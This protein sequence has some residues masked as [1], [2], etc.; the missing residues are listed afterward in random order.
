LKHLSRIS[1]SSNVYIQK[2]TGGITKLLGDTARSFFLGGP[3]TDGRPR[4]GGSHDKLVIARSH[5]HQAADQ[6][7][8]DAIFM[9]AN[10]NF[11][12]NYSHPRNLSHAFQR[13]QQLADLNG[14]SSAQHMIGFYYASGIGGVVKEDQA[15]AMLYYTFAAEQGNERAQ[16]ALAYRYHFGIGTSKNCQSAVRYWQKV[17]KRAIQHIRTGPPG[18]HM[19]IR[20][21]YRIADDTGGIYGEGASVTSAGANAKVGPANSDAHASHSDILE[22]LD[23]IS[24]KGDLKAT[25]SLGRMY[26][27]GARDM[28]PDMGAAKKYFLEVARKYWTKAGKVRS[29]PTAQ[30][31]QLAAKAAGYLGWMFLR[32]EGTEQN[33]DLAKKWLK[34]GVT[35][36]NSLSQYALGLMYLDGLSVPK[37][38]KQA[39]N[40]FSAAADQDHGPSQARL[41]ILYLDAGDIK[42]ALMYFELAARKGSSIEA[43]Y[44]LA[45]SERGGIGQEASCQSAAYHFKHLVE[46]AEPI[47]TSF[48]EANAAYEAGD[49]DAALINYMLIAE[50]GYEVAQTNVAYLLDRAA[51]R[52]SFIHLPLPK[53]VTKVFRSAISI[54]L[55]PSLALLYWTRSARQFNIDALVKM[56]DYYLGGIGAPASETKAAACYQAAA[57]TMQSA[58]ALWNIG[59]MYENGLGGYEQDFHLAK[60][61]YDQALEI[62]REA[63]LPVKLALLKLRLRSRWNEWTRGSAISIQDEPRKRRRPGS[64]GEWIA[65]FLAAE[66]DAIAGRFYDDGDEGD[67][68]YEAASRLGDLTDEELML[69]LFDGVVE[70]GIILLLAAVLA[71]LVIY[72]RQ[73]ADRRAR[74]GDELAAGLAEQAPLMAEEEEEEQGRDNGD[75]EPGRDRNLFPRPGEPGYQDWAVGGIGH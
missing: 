5:L 10:M 29:D 13:Y 70:V 44:Y 27:E 72:R 33:Y 20:S 67:D 9:L 26:F 6:N 73:R 75:E 43:L 65:D 21:G 14:N 41:G 30:T 52:E 3:P 74:D 23:L 64:L 57:E 18:H 54:P 39:A 53:S 7:H 25:F 51:H 56:G 48:E 59:W 42:T 66:A 8:S 38:P 11:F 63:Y 34:R 68:G 28:K 47:M 49:V 50:Q 24:R 62:N 4:V 12:G 32:G 2:R 71:G 37:D 40:Y 15:K 58:Q 22:W 1:P 31:E 36:G 35:L 46:K 55:K 17:A 61:F 69:E 45:E 16:M 19:L 60:R